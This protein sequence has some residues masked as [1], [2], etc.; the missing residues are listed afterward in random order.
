MTSS[1]VCA[2]LRGVGQTRLN[3]L[4]N[5]GGWGEA[6]HLHCAVKTSLDAGSHGM[7]LLCVKHCECVLLVRWGEGN[8]FVLAG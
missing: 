6:Q 1:V 5:V 2:A 3:C 7:L 4:S 8:G